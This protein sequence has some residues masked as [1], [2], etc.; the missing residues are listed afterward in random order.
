MYV[1]I[2]Y[3][4]KPVGRYIS[5]KSPCKSGQKKK[6]PTSADCNMMR[7]KPGFQPRKR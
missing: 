7:E 1:A 3:P 6:D 2:D 5:D 4:T